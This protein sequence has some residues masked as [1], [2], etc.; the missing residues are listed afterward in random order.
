MKKSL[1]LN[2][3]SS[4]QLLMFICC[5]SI[6]FYRAVALQSVLLIILSI[7]VLIKNIKSFKLNKT[8]WPFVTFGIFLSAIYIINYDQSISLKKTGE[9]LMLFIIPI[10]SQNFFIRNNKIINRKNLLIFYT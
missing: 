5:T 1:F 7:L 4:V 10:I 3:D 2:L 9:S 8:N 6:V